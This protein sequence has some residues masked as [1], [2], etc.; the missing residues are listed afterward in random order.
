[1]QQ[2][3]LI[4]TED[5]KMAEHYGYIWYVKI[6]GEEKPATQVEYGIKEHS[7]PDSIYLGEF[8]GRVERTVRADQVP[9][10]EHVEDVL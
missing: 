3:F 7:W 4:S 8:D 9:V 6:N 1:M 2:P 5:G 10:F